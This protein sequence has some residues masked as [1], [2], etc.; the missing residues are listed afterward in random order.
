MVCIC[1][2][3][4]SLAF[5]LGTVTSFGLEED[6]QAD[7]RLSSSEGHSIFELV[8]TANL[9]SNCVH[10]NK[11]SRYLELNANVISSLL[12]IGTSTIVVG[13]QVGLRNS[14]RGGVTMVV[15]FPGIRADSLLE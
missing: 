12:C 15:P 8:I 6:I 14:V 13:L 4:A 11:I 2:V 5:K 1:P 7:Q 10:S 9:I 3:P